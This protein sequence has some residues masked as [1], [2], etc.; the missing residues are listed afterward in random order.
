M[1]GFSRRGAP[2]LGVVEGGEVCFLG[3][4]GAALGRREGRPEGVPVAALDDG[5]EVVKVLRALRGWRSASTRARDLTL[6]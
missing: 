5:G 2:G 1:K 3:G 6:H 4:G